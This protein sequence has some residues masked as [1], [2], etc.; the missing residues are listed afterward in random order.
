[1]TTLSDLATQLHT[2]GSQLVCSHACLLTRLRLDSDE[3][4]FECG[5][6]T[7]CTFIQSF[8]IKNHNRFIKKWIWIQISINLVNI[9]KNRN[10]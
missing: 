2:C 10:H 8:Q 9:W 5:E 7:S 1:M 4:D 3:T 6:I